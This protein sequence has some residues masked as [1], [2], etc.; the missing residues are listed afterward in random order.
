[1]WRSSGASAPVLSS[2][3]SGPQ[4]LREA[5]RRGQRPD[6]PWSDGRGGSRRGGGARTGATRPPSARGGETGTRRAG[7]SPDR[8]P[9]SRR[10]H[11]APAPRLSLDGGGHGGAIDRTVR[12][13]GRSGALLQL[14]RRRRESGSSA[15]Y[16]L[17]SGSEL[18]GH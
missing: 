16:S 4:T 11:L 12:Y 8:V 6:A 17:R 15:R 7:A 1:M 3:S 9:S 18:S 14:R 13:R 5:A 2:Y 10:S